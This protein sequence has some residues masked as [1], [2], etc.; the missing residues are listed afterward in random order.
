MSG[1]RVLTGR[2]VLQLLDGRD[3]ELVAAVTDAYR[4][5]ADG[6]TELPHSMFLRFPDRPADRIIALPAYLGGPA[7]VAGVKWISSFPANVAAGKER[8]S[9]VV[10]LNSMTDGRPRLIAE[11]SVISARRTAAGAVLA[12]GLLHQGER[13]P[14]VGAVGCGRIQFEILRFLCSYGPRPD[15]VVLVDLDPRRRDRLAGAI[16]GWGVTCTEAPDID[17]ALRACDIVSF[18]TTASTPHVAGLGGCPQGAT[19]LHVSLRD[20]TAEAVAG[21]D[22]VVDDADHVCRAATS[23]DLAVQ[24]FGHRDFVRTSIGE[25]LAGRQP[26]RT[27]GERPV[28][29]SPFGL[30]IL[31]LAVARLVETLAAQVGAG[32]LVEDFQPD[33]WAPD[34]LVAAMADGRADDT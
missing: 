29:F 18:A 1:L 27:G 15:H 11:G 34:P 3:A 28:V 16:A 9:A 13:S 4:A 21:C 22:N 12:A 7:D 10:V 31:D 14:V 26:A 19:I 24:K 25:I 2:Q 33:D 17:T 32:L 23:L 5:H 20:L 30:G 8:A 6:L